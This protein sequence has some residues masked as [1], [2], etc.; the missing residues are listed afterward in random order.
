MTVVQKH[1]LDTVL[2]RWVD[3]SV[4]NDPAPLYRLNVRSAAI[5]PVGRCFAYSPTFIF[6]LCP[7]STSMSKV[8][9]KD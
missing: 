8:F 4:I 5:V 7:T 2:R 3:A 1:I 9:R 6:S